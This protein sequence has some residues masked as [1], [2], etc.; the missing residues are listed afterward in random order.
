MSDPAFLTEV[1]QHMLYRFIET[2][3][4]DEGYDIGKD[5]VKRL[6][7]LGVVQNHGFGHYS[8]TAFGWWAHETF[9]HQSPTLPLKTNAD[10]DSDFQARIPK[11]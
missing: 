4:D 5:G 11:D 2:T 9:W 10:R 1:D 3:D 7:E 6:A 8:V